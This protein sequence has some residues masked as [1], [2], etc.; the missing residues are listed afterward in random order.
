M[1]KII[2]KKSVT[3]KEIDLITNCFSYLG[4]L[5]SS[6]ALRTKAEINK[7]IANYFSIEFVA[8]F[9]CFHSNFR[10]ILYQTLSV[11]AFNKLIMQ[12]LNVIIIS[13]ETE[14]HFWKPLTGYLKCDSVLNMK[15][16]SLRILNKEEKHGKIFNGFRSR[17]HKFKVYSI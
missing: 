5:M 12:I 11:F 7:A 14:L 1:L 2:S 16:F 3:E 13:I 15:V 9:S 4:K 8:F 17:N 6:I 10:A